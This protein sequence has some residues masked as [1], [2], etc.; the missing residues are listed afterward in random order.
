MK[1]HDGDDGFEAMP[2]FRAAETA[3]AAPAI[4]DASVTKS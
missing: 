3:G 4:N 2:F 1:G